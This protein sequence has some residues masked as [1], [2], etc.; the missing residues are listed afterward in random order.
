MKSPDFLEVIEMDLT[1]IPIS[2]TGSDLEARA[3]SLLGVL[4]SLLRMDEW[5]QRTELA[6]CFRV[7]PTT[8]G[9]GILL[10]AGLRP[11]ILRACPRGVRCTVLRA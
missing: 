6:Y 8:E 11:S 10:V 3:D 9:G 7:K 2:F 4:C 1:G 5:L